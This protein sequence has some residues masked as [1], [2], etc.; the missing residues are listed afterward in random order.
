[1][2]IFKRDVF[3]NENL[4]WMELLESSG[5]KLSSSRRGSLG[6]RGEIEGRVAPFIAIV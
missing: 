5:I 4:G 6:P 2:S 1:M 3:K